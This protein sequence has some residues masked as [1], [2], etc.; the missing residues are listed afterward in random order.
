MPVAATAG[1]VGGLIR[2]FMPNTEEIWR[3]G[4][5][6]FMSTPRWLV[7]LFRGK[8]VTWEMLPLGACVVLELARQALGHAT[9]PQWLFY[10]ERREELGDRAGLAL[11]GDGRRGSD[12][13]LEQHAPRNESRAAP[14]VAAQ[15]AHGRADRANQSSFFVQHAQ[16]RVVA[17][18]LRS[19]H[20]ARRGHQAEQ[21]FAAALAQARDVRAPAGGTRFYR[22]LSGYRGRALRARQSCDSQAD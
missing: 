5:Y 18:S 3:L 15:G 9:K 13:D 22:R 10:L 14:A 6:T 19:G 20:G 1:L 7:R 2:Q 8:K 12:E 11:H 21:Y 4:P 17:D 16:Y